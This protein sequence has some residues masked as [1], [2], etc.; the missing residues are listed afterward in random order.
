MIVWY[1]A[2]QSW[3]GYRTQRVWVQNIL[4][5]SW[6]LMNVQ[7]TLRKHAR[8]VFQSWAIDTKKLKKANLDSS[9]SQR[10]RLSS[11]SRDLDQS[12]I[13]Q[14]IQLN[15]VGSGVPAAHPHTKT[16]KIPLSSPPKRNR[17]VKQ[18]DHVFFGVLTSS[19]NPSKLVNRVR[20]S[21]EKV[22]TVVS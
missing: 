7:Y 11:V 5:F 2:V 4:S 6:K 8:N 12:S 20:M 14:P 17:L 10:K 21:L 1:K 13:G 3:I 22:T 18:K 9:A 15:Q 19:F 16:S